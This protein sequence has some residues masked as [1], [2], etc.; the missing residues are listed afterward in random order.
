MVFQ[1]NQTLLSAPPYNMIKE[2]L[3]SLAFRSCA[4]TLM[5]RLGLPPKVRQ[6]S[7][8]KAIASH[9]QVASED[10]AEIAV[11]SDGFWPICT[12][13]SKGKGLLRSSRPS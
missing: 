3:T 10:D 9:T 1:G 11:N 5:D 12:P 2:G 7:S 8:G 6:Q 4:E 13:S